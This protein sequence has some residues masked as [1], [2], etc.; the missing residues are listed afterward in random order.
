MARSRSDIANTA[1]RIFL[2]EIGKEYDRE[3]GLEPFG[4]KHLKGEVL[5]FFEARCCFCGEGLTPSRTCGDHLIP[6][7][8]KDLGLDAWGNVVPACGACNSAKHGSDWRDFI[9]QQAGP[10][11]AERHQRMRE[12]LAAYP[13]WPPLELL[14]PIVADLYNEAGAVAMALIQ[15]KI[16]RTR[17]AL[18]LPDR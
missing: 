13:Y 11:A 12:F 3:R 2:Q 8:Q 10:D 14:R 16:L 18:R 15:A 4:K 5:E 7:N 17:E 9:I 6:I 1:V